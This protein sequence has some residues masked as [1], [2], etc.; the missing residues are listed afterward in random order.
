MQWCISFKSWGP[1]VIR[2]RF[3][4]LGPAVK[5]EHCIPNSYGLVKRPR[6][7]FE[8]IGQECDGINRVIVASGDLDAECWHPKL[9][10]S[11]QKI[12]RRFWIHQARMRR[13]KKTIMAVEL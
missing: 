4:V 11:C 1:S 3:E 2:G 13:K 8:P 5:H 6:E 12:L 10:W 9:E 7:N